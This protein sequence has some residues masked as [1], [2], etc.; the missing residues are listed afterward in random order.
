MLV[1]NYKINGNDFTSLPNDLS[2][3]Y[4]Y[5]DIKFL[6]L[7]NE[8]LR[9]LENVFK[10]YQISIDRIL[11]FDYVNNFFE[12]QDLN[13]FEKAKKIADG[14]NDNEVKFINKINENKGFFE[15]IF[16]FFS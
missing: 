16:N 9:N 2:C 4:F 6:C 13:L 5:L 8:Y 12:S 10:K 1:N 11:D 3:N 7:S 14:C 15:K